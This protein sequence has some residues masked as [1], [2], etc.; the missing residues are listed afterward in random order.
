MTELSGKSNPAL[1]DA[2]PPV[3]HAASGA[4]QPNGTDRALF[5][6]PATN[7]VTWRS[8]NRRV[9]SVTSIPRTK[10]DAVGDS[11]SG[12]RNTPLA[13]FLY[14]SGYLGPEKGKH[15]GTS[16]VRKGRPEKEEGEGG[17][18]EGGLEVD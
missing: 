5:P 17:R 2:S 9:G 8:V 14:N 13:M 11:Q 15:L 18:R 3:H 6:T 7:N 16:G 4:V 10:L 1:V 12:K